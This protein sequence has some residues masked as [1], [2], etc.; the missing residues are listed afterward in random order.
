M[1]WFKAAVLAAIIVL[2]WKFTLK[3]L[4]NTIEHKLQDSVSVYKQVLIDNG[5]AFPN[6]AICQNVLETGM[7][8]SKV[9]KENHN[10]FGMKESSRTFDIGTKNKH[11]NYPHTPHPGKCTIECYK[12]AIKDYAAWQAAFH[13]RERCFSDEQYI[14]YLQH[15]PGN[16]RYAEDR[17]YE[18]KLLNILNLLK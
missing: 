4:D 1:S 12:P 7:F 13:V 6:V 11:A 10:P 9:F 3:F 14:Y 8:S 17:Q 18:S 2:S 16:R 5:V 15:L